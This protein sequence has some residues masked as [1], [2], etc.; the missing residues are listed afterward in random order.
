MIVQKHERLK[1]KYDSLKRRKESS[2]N[3]ENES[4]QKRMTIQPINVK[5]TDWEEDQD[6]GS[7]KDED[8][9]LPPIY[10]AD[11]LK[12]RIKKALLQ[13]LHAY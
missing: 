13:K 6:K 9:D 2:G 8:D 12:G 4:P 5:R 11:G 7:E 10:T 1:E 3:L